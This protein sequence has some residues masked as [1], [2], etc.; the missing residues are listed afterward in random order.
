[1]KKAWILDTDL[2]WDPDDIIALLL[3]I[4]YIKISGDLFAVI[5]SD[6]TL[7]NNRAWVIKSIVDDLLPENNVIIASGIN[8][9]S[10]RKLISKDL[11]HYAHSTHS[12][13]NSNT[14]ADVNTI[15]QFISKT[16]AD[17]YFVTWIGIGAM[18]N[19]AFI[20]SANIKLNKI[21]QMGGSFYNEVEYN[22]KLDPDAC[23]YVL[24]HF[25]DNNHHQNEP[26][27]LE[28]VT[29]DTT[30]YN[31]SWLEE[32]SETKSLKQRIIPNI[33][34]SLETKFP[35]VLKVIKENVYCDEFKS[36]YASSSAL[37]D[38]LTVIYALYSININMTNSYTQCGASGIWNSV[39]DN[40]I[41]EQYNN[42]NKISYWWNNTNPTI[43]EPIIQGQKYNCKVSLG[44]LSCSQIETFT[45]IMN[46]LLFI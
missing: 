2:G 44:P 17:G 43:K 26:N 25:S 30:G 42:N 27:I 5:S 34:K 32:Y 7:E 35:S 37:H 13:H 14:I 9:T 6:E 23:V 22:I 21:I 3:L 31:L 38:P 15:C 45:S 28:F 39:I 18:T 1:M 16:Q 20:L 41:I 12:K 46:D 24:A 4:Q 19:L 11:L 10:H 36:G 33:W 29:L 8:S 40:N